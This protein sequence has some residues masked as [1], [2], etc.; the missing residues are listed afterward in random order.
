MSLD[1]SIKSINKRVNQI[2]EY[3]GTNSIEYHRFKNLLYSQIPEEFREDVLTLGKT[4]SIALSRSKQAKEIYS[5]YGLDSVIEDIWTKMKTSKMFGTVRNNVRRYLNAEQM[6]E[7]DKNPNTFREDIRNWSEDLYTSEYGDFDLYDEIKDEIA[8]ETRVE[9]REQDDVY[10]QELQTAL[11][12]LKQKGRSR[13][14]KYNEASRIFFRARFEHEQRV[15][16]WFASQAKGEE[17]KI[18]DTD[19]SL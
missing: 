13:E 15:R 8:R 6:R 14:D 2:R 9:N 1:S 7:F 5:D 12:I 17:F 10:L 16:E 3:F 18:N 4:G 19:M 11:G